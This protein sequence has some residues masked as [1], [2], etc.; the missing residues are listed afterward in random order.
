MDMEF[1]YGLMEPDMKGSGSKTR[2][3]ERES[4][5][6][7]MEMFSMDNGKTTRQMVMEYMFT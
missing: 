4:F 7:S 2:L 3:V 5:G 1:K 6:M